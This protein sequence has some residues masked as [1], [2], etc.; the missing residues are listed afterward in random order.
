MENA[1]GVSRNISMVASRK[2]AA[3]RTRGYHKNFY[4]FAL[5]KTLWYAQRGFLLAC[6]TPDTA[7]EVPQKA[8]LQKFQ[9]WISLI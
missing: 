6:G 4:S 1:K 7:R 5:P 2:F 8:K 3:I 9:N